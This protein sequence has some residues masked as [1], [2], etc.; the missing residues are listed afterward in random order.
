MSCDTAKFII[1]K[2]S[3]NTFVFT[4]KQDNSTLPLTIVEETDT[5]LASLVALKDDSPYASITNTTLDVISA[6]NGKISLTIP[7]ADTLL[8][9]TSKGDEA[10][11][12]YLRPTYKLVM[13]C[14]TVNNGSFIA[15]VNE[16]YVD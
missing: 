4:I 14:V 1:T 13:N 16:V 12:Y 6:A 2:G 5:F 8:L 11:R 15:K 10:D 3:E 7:S 9:V